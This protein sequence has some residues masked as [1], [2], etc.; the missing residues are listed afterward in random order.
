MINIVQICRHLHVG[1][2]GTASPYRFFARDGTA[3]PGPEYLRSGRTVA[4]PGPME[5]R[6]CGTA[7]GRLFR[8]RAVQC[9]GANSRA[10]NGCLQGPDKSSV[11]GPLVFGAGRLP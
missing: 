10:S 9:G 5:P 7:W 8:G 11:A 1:W 6:R 4:F 2:P 3:V